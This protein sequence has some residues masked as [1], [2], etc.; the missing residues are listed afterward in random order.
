MHSCFL[1]IVVVLLVLAALFLG[2]Q[3]G[4][5]GLHTKRQ[6][7]LTSQA[8][9]RPEWKGLQNMED[10]VSPSTLLLHEKDQ[11]P[12]TTCPMRPKPEP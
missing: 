7:L 8:C 11:C 5:Q 10:K 9:I 1:G 3:G 6:L 4:K 2:M 12:S